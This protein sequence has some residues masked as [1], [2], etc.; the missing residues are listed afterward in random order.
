MDVAVDDAD[1]KA[2]NRET[3][4]VAGSEAG[5]HIEV[6]TGAG[7]LDDGSPKRSLAERVSRVRTL[8][9]HRVDRLL[10]AKEPDL[11]AIDANAQTSAVGNVDDA[12]D[13]L[14]AHEILSKPGE[15]G[16]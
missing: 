13:L 4:C 11:D 12:G 2:G 8:I 5:S 14:K 6:P 10:H 1:Q 9:F 16:A 7:A 3:V 15:R